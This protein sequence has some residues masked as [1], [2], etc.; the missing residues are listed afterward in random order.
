MQKAKKIIILVLIGFSASIGLWLNANADITFIGLIATTNTVNL[1]MTNSVTLSNFTIYDFNNRIGMQYSTETFRNYTFY[2]SSSSSIYDANMTAI[3]ASHAIFYVVT[4]SLSDVQLNI[5]GT[6]LDSVKLDDIISSNW[7]WNGTVNTIRVQSAKKIEIFFPAG[8]SFT[9]NPTDTATVIDALTK[10]LTAIRTLTDSA[11]VS[12]LLTKVYVG[13]RTLTDSATISDVL[14]QLYTGTRTLTDSAT[15]SDVLSKVYVGARTL[16]DSELI[17]DVMTTILTATRTLTDSSL[18]SDL[19]SSQLSASKSLT[20]TSTIT[21]ILTTALSTPSGGTAPPPIIQP[22][23]EEPFKPVEITLSTN[24]H[25]A[26]VN[27]IIPDQLSIQWN[28][29]KDLQINEVIVSE[30]PFIIQFEPTPLIIKGD[31]NTQSQGKLSYTIQVPPNLCSK[32]IT[33]NCIEPKKYRI[34]IEVST[35]HGAILIHKTSEIDIDLSPAQFNLLYFIENNQIAGINTT[36]ILILLS[37]ITI[38][39]II[40][41]GEAKRR[42]KKDESL[43]TTVKRK[44][45]KENQEEIL[46]TI[47]TKFGFDDSEVEIKLRESTPVKTL[48]KTLSTGSAK[49]TESIKKITDSRTTYQRKEQIVDA[50]KSTRSAL[51]KTL[52]DIDTRTEKVEKNFTKSFQKTLG[53]DAKELA[54]S[55]KKVK[56]NILSKSL[57]KLK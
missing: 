30:S 47:K 53:N 10:T 54:K 57:K 48:E 20:D 22:P 5:T 49:V 25:K 31:P 36:T 46:T 56:K 21:D 52:H 6:Q 7:S 11:S 2:R 51:A 27:E 35:Y 26:T 43:K 34:P 33:Q 12:D 16:T 18:I 39:G 1:N 24:A 28:T 23:F 14:T 8:Q 3:D 19:L 4:G 38:I 41:F 17:S 50:T 55:L 29:E 15:V 44:D 32:T 42:H 9:Q 40:I 37:A 45:K 13:T